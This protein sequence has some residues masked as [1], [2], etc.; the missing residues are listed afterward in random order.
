MN[1]FS[2]VSKNV[3]K[4]INK[5]VDGNCGAKTP[6]AKKKNLFCQ[7]MNSESKKKMIHAMKARILYEDLK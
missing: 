1:F 4:A 2:E 6:S 3:Q 5:I 7:P